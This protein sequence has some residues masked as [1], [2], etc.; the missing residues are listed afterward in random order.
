M[1]TKRGSYSIAQQGNAMALAERVK[2]DKEYHNDRRSAGENQTRLVRLRR[3][4]AFD[5]ISSPQ[6]RALGKAGKIIVKNA[7]AGKSITK[8]IKSASRSAAMTVAEQKLLARTES[9]SHEQIINL[10]L[11]VQGKRQREILFAMPKMSDATKAGIWQKVEAI[12][13]QKHFEKVRA[14]IQR[15]LASK[16]THKN[17]LNG[18]AGQLMTLS[19][20][21][22]NSALA[23][24]GLSTGTRQQVLS[25]VASRETKTK[26]FNLRKNWADTINSLPKELRPLYRAFE[27]FKRIEVR[28]R[29][30]EVQQRERERGL[31]KSQQTTLEEFLKNN[32][33]HTTEFFEFLRKAAS[34]RK[35]SVEE[36]KAHFG[37]K[38]M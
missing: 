12:R 35:M 19:P 7:L 34:E 26:K 23:D 2:A 37:S 38:K 31:V 3:Q 30:E 5:L 29:F 13:S 33:P 17:K 9:H 36:L 18:I 8:D 1:K 16:A 10:L 22:R 11:Q 25:I 6:W 4:Q 20:K 14:H 28:G 24:F 21:A 27:K 32:K 15:V